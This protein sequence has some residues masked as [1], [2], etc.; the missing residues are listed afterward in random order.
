M[1]IVFSRPIS[2]HIHPIPDDLIEAQFDLF[3]KR[4]LKN[5]LRSKPSKDSVISS[6]DLVE[7]YLMYDNDKRVKWLSPPTVISFDPNSW[8]VTLPAGNGRTMNSSIE[9]ILHALTGE[10]LAS[11]VLQANGTLYSE[12]Q[13]LLRLSAGPPILSGHLMILNTYRTHS[14]I[15]LSQAL[16]APSHQPLVIPSMFWPIDNSYYGDTIQ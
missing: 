8:T 5:I 3:S 7:V 11:S 2:S 13:E 14:S 1:A 9:D 12:L 16:P 15:P 4:K 6:G 10:S